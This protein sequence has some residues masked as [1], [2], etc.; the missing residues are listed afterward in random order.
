MSRSESSSAAERA[1][2]IWGELLSAEADL[3]VFI[4]NGWYLGEYLPEERDRLTSVPSCFQHCWLEVDG[5]IFDPSRPVGD[6]ASDDAYLL[7]E[8]VALK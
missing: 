8:R 4:V 7:Y 2:E 5:E 1:T 6:Q 3:D